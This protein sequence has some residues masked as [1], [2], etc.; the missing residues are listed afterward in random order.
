M[1]PRRSIAPRSPVLGS[2]ECSVKKWPITKLLAAA[3][4]SGFSLR[5]AHP[6]LPSFR[7]SKEPRDVS[8]IALDLC[9]L[10]AV[11][12]REGSAAQAHI[13]DDGFGI[14]LLFDIDDPPSSSVVLRRVGGA[15][16]QRKSSAVCE[17]RVPPDHPRA[18]AS[19][20]RPFAPP[21]T[22]APWQLVARTRSV[23][24]SRMRSR[25]PVSTNSSRRLPRGAVNEDFG[26][27]L[28]RRATLAGEK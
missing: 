8:V 22:R 10:I 9:K 1:D 13:V 26:W 6:N 11:D 18:A 25:S 2:V 7:N 3:K 24:R 23:P 14:P 12:N 19:R 20:G 16:V 15:S 5:T 27:T 4:S 28:G 17:P 21:T